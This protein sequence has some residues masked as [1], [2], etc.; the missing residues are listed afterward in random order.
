[1]GESVKGRVGRT[2]EIGLKHMRGGTCAG[3]HESDRKRKAVRMA[4]NIGMAGEGRP[5]REKGT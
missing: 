5:T 1:M 3:E 4:G 2:C